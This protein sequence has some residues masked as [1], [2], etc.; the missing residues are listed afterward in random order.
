[1]NKVL[2]GLVILLTA[3]VGYLYYEHYAYINAD[4]HNKEKDKAV[5]MNALKI[6]YFELDSVESSYEYYKEVKDYLTKKD[7]SN[8]TQLNKIKNNYLNKAKEYQQKGPNMSQ[9]EQSE[10]QQSLMKLQNDYS[11]TEQNLN[12]EMQAEMVEKMQA[13]KKKIQDYL[14]SYCAEKGYSYVF[15]SNDNDY[16]YY[17][18]SIRNITPDIIK[19]LN[20]EHKK[21]KEK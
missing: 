1:M 20:D 4:V 10:Y 16:L 19:G 17:K 21:N 3:A 8:Q 15:A 5:I 9:N 18:D 11:E 12:N 14:K 2:L 13:V 6:A 7:Q